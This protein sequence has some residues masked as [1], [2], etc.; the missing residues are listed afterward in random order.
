MPV[1]D[2]ETLDVEV[3]AVASEETLA[4]DDLGVSLSAEVVSD[5]VLDELT[6]VVALAGVVEF[7]DTIVLSRVEEGPDGVELKELV[8]R[9][10]G[11]AVSVVASLDVVALE[12]DG[13]LVS[14]GVVVVA[15]VVVVETATVVVEVAA[16][17][18]L[19]D[20]FVLAVGV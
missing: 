9:S 5:S 16:C 14:V 15:T 6:D 12:F 10:D 3:V 17:E 13:L 1:V 8:G 7:G 4:V 2:K 11:V 19:V 20:V 18:V